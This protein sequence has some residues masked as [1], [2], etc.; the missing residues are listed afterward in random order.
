M[1]SP[2]RYRSNSLLV[3]PKIWRP[4]AF[5]KLIH[6][7]VVESPREKESHLADREGPKFKALSIAEQGLPPPVKEEAV[8]RLAD[9]ISI[10]NNAHLEE[11]KTA[12][13]AYMYDLR[14]ALINRRR[15]FLVHMPDRPRP[16]LFRLVIPNEVMRVEVLLKWRE[17]LREHGILDLV[18]PL[19]EEQQRILL[20][21]RSEVKKAEIFLEK[22]RLK[23]LKAEA[24]VEPMPFPSPSTSVTL[25]PLPIQ[26][27]VR[28]L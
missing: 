25:P 19:T 27:R 12:F 13:G 17:I 7:A 20:Q 3:D 2:R 4:H 11:F 22:V 15:S 9:S 14:I 28:H 16:A 23:R 1:E 10:V 24:P 26:Q 18:P 21:F 5:S 8:H 6:Q